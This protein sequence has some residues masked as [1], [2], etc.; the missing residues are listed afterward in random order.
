MVAKKL[1]YQKRGN[2]NPFSISHFERLLEI[3]RD[4]EKIFALEND[5][6]EIYEKKWDKFITQH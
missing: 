4:A 3:A 2:R 1:I 6:L 5:K